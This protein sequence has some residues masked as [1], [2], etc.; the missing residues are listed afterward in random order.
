M[1]VPPYANEEPPKLPAGTLNA[2]TYFRPVCCING[3][4]PVVVTRASATASTVRITKESAAN[5]R[6]C[7]VIR[8]P[9]NE[10]NHDSKT[11][12]RPEEY[13]TVRGQIVSS[14]LQQG[15][16]RC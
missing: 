11:R 6:S 4:A 10:S 8:S 2:P 9:E 16:C 5:R 15:R 12:N 3:S 13:I 1:A 7:V 14:V